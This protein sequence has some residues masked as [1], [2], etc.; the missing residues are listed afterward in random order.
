MTTMTNWTSFATGAGARVTTWNYD[1][2]RGWLTNKTYPDGTA[3]TYTNTAAG[4][5]ALRIWARGTNT[6]YS[7]NGAGDRSGITYSDGVTPN[8]TYGYDRRGRQNSVTQGS[9]TTTRAFDDAGDL[10]SESYSGGPL[11]GLAITNSFDS[12]LRRTA[13]ALSNQT[14]TL[15]QYGYDAASRL[16][17]VANGTASA[18]YVYLANSPLVSQIA[19]TNSGVQSMLTTK[20]YDNLNR[21]TSISSSP[22][23]GSAISFAYAYNLANQRTSVTNADG[24]FWVYTY[25]SLGQVT[26]GTK[27][28]NDGT[29][30]PGLQFQYS[31][32]DIGN[33]KTTAAGGDQWGAKLR[34]ANYTVNN[35]NQYTSRTVP[36][37]LDVIGTATNTATVTVNNQASSRKGMYY[38][39]PVVLNNS[40][41]AVWA[42]L[43]NLA[44]LN[45]GS[46]PDITTNWTANAFLPQTPESFGYDADGNLTNDG[47]WTYTWDGENR[48]VSMQGLS[49]LP[50]GAKLKLD[51]AYDEQGRRIQKI[52]STN[53]GSAYYPQNTN[54]FVYDGWNLIAILNPPSSI[55]R[56]FVWGLDLSGSVRRVGGVGGLLI[57]NDALYGAY[58]V[59]SDANG[60]V[61]ALWRVS[62]QWWDAQYE[63]GPF[64]ELLRASGPSARANPFRFSSKYQ[65]DESDLLYYGWRFFTPARGNWISADP[66]GQTADRNLTAFARNDPNNRFDP[67][68]RIT[69]SRV[70]PTIT[71][72]CGNY[73]VMWTFT[74]DAPAPSD[75]YIVQKITT[76]T[77]YA[78][79]GGSPAVTSLVFWE[80]WPVA[81]GFT[82][83]PGVSMPLPFGGGAFY[84]DTDIYRHPL[85]SWGYHAVQG[86]IKFFTK[87]RIGEIQESGFELGNV[88]MSG[89]LPSTQNQPSWWSQ[90]SSN[91]ER[92][93]SRFASANWSCCCGTQFSLNVYNLFSFSP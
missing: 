28:A 69:V 36:G 78:P 75:G 87:D 23:G 50:T 88:G 45:N 91:G 21:M 49:T 61:G 79:C 81:E 5:L 29:A 19:F 64:G 46:N 66:L 86:E 6:V 34:Y 68:G 13:V 12:F 92:T 2:C 72:N 93:G 76:K 56:S 24:S 20:N 30:L 14:S 90:A 44:V 62:D 51:F 7:Y 33:R 77:S 89:S 54:R 26:S 52:V 58:F 1:L 38:D 84:T 18:A 80:A 9:I 67:D 63:Y 17:T 8:V 25:D 41:G 43:T 57:G 55:L 3:V 48:L 4:R 31:F 32:D 10:L 40:S 11:S 22:S 35:L 16:S 60:N 37:A 70:F 65:D 85:S 74:L 71:A 47:R 15:V 39:V 27:Y 73:T 59:V 82:S 53:N 42:S 83:P